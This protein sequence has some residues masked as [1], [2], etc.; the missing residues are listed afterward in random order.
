VSGGLAA[1]GLPRR[2]HRNVGTQVTSYDRIPA[3]APDRWDT[4]V[5]RGLAGRPRLQRSAPFVDRSAAIG[6]LC[7]D[8]HCF[9][10]VCSNTCTL[11]A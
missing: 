1:R 3:W 7:S 8:V 2:E 6:G 9:A 10:Q 11:R 4:A 5:R